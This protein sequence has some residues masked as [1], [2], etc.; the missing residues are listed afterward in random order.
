MGAL[1]EFIFQFALVFPGAFFRWLLGGCKK[2]YS[3]YLDAS[4]EVNVLVA[5]I[6]FALIAFVITWAI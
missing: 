3:D 1:L 4:P 2:K 5:I 6:F